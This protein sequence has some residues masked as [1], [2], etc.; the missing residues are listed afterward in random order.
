LADQPT[1]FHGRRDSKGVKLKVLC[2]VDGRVD[3]PDR[4]IWNYLSPDAQRDAVDF[5]HVATRDLFPKWGKLLTSYPAYLSLALKALKQ[6]REA[7]YDL[8]VAWE[9]KNGFPLAILRGMLRLT[10]PKLVILAF[11]YKGIAMHFRRVGRLGMR[12]IDHITVP[13]RSEIEYYHRL[14]GFP[15]E[16]IT[17]VPLG[18]Y[19][20]ASALGISG[21]ETGNHIFAGGRSWRDYGTL[22]DAM[23]DIDAQLI[24]NARKFNVQGLACPPNVTIN[25]F[26]SGREYYALMAGARLVVVPLQDTP[27]AAGLGHVIQAMSVGKAVVATRT[28][29]TVDYVEDGQTGILVPPYDAKALR[30]AITHLL[31]H[32]E[33]AK[34]MGRMARQRYEEK[35]TF[36]A[37]ARRTWDVLHQV[38]MVR[39]PG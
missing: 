5:M 23:L 27:Y 36:A 17:F 3:L 12:G 11:A 14:L 35:Y 25:G 9:S 4:W 39:E 2:L 24:V 7:D 34:A 15:L 10:K 26:M 21:E 38:T 13:S 20:L 28:A 19:D 8:I 18:S 37:F 16:K 33:E 31:T 30:S 22:F 6:S 32:A 29:S 1:P